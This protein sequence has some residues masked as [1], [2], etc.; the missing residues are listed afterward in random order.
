MPP[1]NNDL[2]AILNAGGQMLDN[3]TALYVR[4]CSRLAATV[5][6]VETVLGL[7]QLSE[8]ENRTSSEG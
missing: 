3:L 4:I 2:A 7:P 8:P 6:A 1:K 5:E